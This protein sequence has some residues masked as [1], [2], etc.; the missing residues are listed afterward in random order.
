MQI[1]SSQIR[2]SFRAEFRA[3]GVEISKSW[4][5][6]P[7]REWALAIELGPQ[8]VDWLSTE[9]RVS[10]QQLLLFLSSLS[11]SIQSLH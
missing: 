2:T 5:A 4:A 9:D 11:T 6:A 3:S 1:S 8:L 7:A 10:E